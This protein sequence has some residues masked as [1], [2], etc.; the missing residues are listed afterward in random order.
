MPPPALDIEQ[1]L[2]TRLLLS[3]VLKFE[4]CVLLF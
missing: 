2:S 4:F 3:S 1:G